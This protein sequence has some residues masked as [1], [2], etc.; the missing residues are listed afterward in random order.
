[1]DE[2]V[3][4][5]PAVD[6]KNKNFGDKDGSKNDNNYIISYYNTFCEY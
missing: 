2:E 1:M 5:R 3:R 4:S 6:I